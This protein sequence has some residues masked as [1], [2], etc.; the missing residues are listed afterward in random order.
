MRILAMALGIGFGTMA[1][2][3]TVVSVG[4]PTEVKTY[5]QHLTFQ[6]MCEVEPAGYTRADGDTPSM[7]YPAY[8]SCVQASIDMD[9]IIRE[10]FPNATK[11]NAPAAADL[12][13]TMNDC[14][15]KPLE[16]SADVEY[17]AQ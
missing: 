5:S 15:K 11:V 17:T 7:P 2:A 9:G 4:Q 16:F 3:T 6:A 1:S 13:Q 12:N 10:K 8:C 14:G